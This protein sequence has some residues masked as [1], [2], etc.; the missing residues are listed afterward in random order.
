MGNPGIVDQDID[1][2]EFLQRRPRRC[3]RPIGACEI[4]F[5]GKAFAPEVLYRRGNFREPRPV[6]PNRRDVGPGIGQHLAGFKADALGGAQLPVRFSP[7][8]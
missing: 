4:G 1:A 5:N 6:A 7:Q 8:G 2:A 3:H